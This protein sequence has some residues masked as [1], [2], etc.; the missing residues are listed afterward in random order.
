MAAEGVV[1]CIANVTRKGRRVDDVYRMA[2]LARTKWSS[3]GGVAHLANQRLAKSPVSS[4]FLFRQRQWENR[5]LLIDT[6]FVYGIE[7]R[8]K[9][10]DDDEHEVHVPPAESQ[11]LHHRRRPKSKVWKNPDWLIE[12]PSA[13]RLLLC[14]FADTT[15][16]CIVL[17]KKLHSDFCSTIIPMALDKR[18]GNLLLA[19]ILSTAAAHRKSL[20]LV[21]DDIAYTRHK[22]RALQLLSRQLSQQPI[23]PTDHGDVCIATSLTLCLCEIL[24]GGEKPNSW[25]AHLKGA[26]ALLGVGRRQ[27]QKSSLTTI[28]A[29][30]TPS[31]KLLRRWWQTYEGHTLFND[32]PVPL[33]DQGQVRPS[34]STRSTS[35][36]NAYID[37]FHGFSIGLLPVIDELNLLIIERQAI[38]DMKNAGLSCTQ[39][40]D[41]VELRGNRLVLDVKGMLENRLPKLHD[42]FDISDASLIL[43][44]W[45][46]LDQAYHH[47]TL[48]K[49]YQRVLGLQS[50]NPNI[51]RAVG[52]AIDCISRITLHDFACPGVALLQPVFTVGCE[53]HSEQ[54]RKFVIAWLDRL[55][56]QNAMGNVDRAK[57]FL[58]ELWH[59]R[60]STSPAADYIH[61]NELLESKGWEL[62]LY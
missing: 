12:L 57:E 31:R 5:A 53:A 41:V 44:D 29:G 54:D 46:D 32:R 16:L 2:K 59:K 20:G 37:D 38:K 40:R 51:Q 50:T 39:L 14:H 23:E 26:A 49:I 18:H 10:Q 61:W 55:R 43:S 9:E 27:S 17:H 35:D 3:R 6:P 7:Q 1:V 25:R 22:E 48:L 33:F 21:C 24:E 36:A 28:D 60:D 30:D 47:I 34:L 52:R 45:A 13:Q 15:V 4:R 56:K 8:L 58:L 62:A 11:L 42:T 19:A